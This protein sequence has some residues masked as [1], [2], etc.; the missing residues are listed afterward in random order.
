MKKD[1]F[2]LHTESR[3]RELAEEIKTRLKLDFTP[4]LEF[5]DDGKRYRGVKLIEKLVEITFVSEEKIYPFVDLMVE[6][7]LDAQTLLLEV[8]RSGYSPRPFGK[9]WTGEDGPYLLCYNQDL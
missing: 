1:D 9:N 5:N 4:K 3:I 2:I 6:E 7:W 8:Q